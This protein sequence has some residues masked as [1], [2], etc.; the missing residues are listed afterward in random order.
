VAEFHA[1][2][3]VSHA[4]ETRRSAVAMILGNSA[5]GVVWVVEVG[6]AGCICIA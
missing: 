2:K 5:L 3:N 1:V 6:G 4:A